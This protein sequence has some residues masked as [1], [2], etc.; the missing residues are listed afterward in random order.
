[1]S[2]TVSNSLLKDVKKALQNGTY[3]N[4]NLARGGKLVLDKMTPFLLVYRFSGAAPD[5]YFGALVRTQTAFLIA[6]EDYDLNKLIRIICEGQ[7]RRFNSFLIIE[8]WE[9][10]DSDYHIFAPQ[11]KVATTVSTLKDALEQ[12]PGYKVP[13]QTTDTADRNPPE[14]EPLLSHDEMHK[15]GVLVI[16]LEIPHT[17]GD[18]SRGEVYPI[19]FRQFRKAFSEAL[20]KAAFDF[21]RVQTNAGFDHYWRLGKSKITNRVRAVDQQLS[22]LSERIDL[23]MRVTPVNEHQQWLRFRKNNF[24]TPPNFSYRLITIDPDEE[25][26]RLFNIPV[27][28]IEDPTLMHIY[29]EK[30]NALEKELIMLE[31]RETDRFV[32]MSQNLIG[33]VR[34]ETTAQANHILEVTRHVPDPDRD[35]MVDCHDFFNAARDELAHYREEF[36]FERLHPEIRDDISGLMVSRGKLLIGTN[37]SVPRIQM[38][39]MLQHEVGT[40]VLTYCNGRRQPMGLLCRGLANYDAL[41]EGMA[42]L[43]EYLADGLITARMRVLAARVIAVNA[44]VNGYDFISTFNLLH[45]EHRFSP[46]KAFDITGRVFRG[47]GYTKDAIYLQGLLGLLDY[48]ENGG[49]LRILFAGKFALE[50]VAFIDE[51]IHREVISEPITPRLLDTPEAKEKLSHIRAGA[52]PTDLITDYHENSIHR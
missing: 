43:M 15:L 1:M 14:V 50:H 10:E 18:R 36:G 49:D 45:E 51:L 5:K 52:G 42:V 25:K 40:H 29:R 37:F 32:T 4:R 44:V 23:L 39:A 3:I 30:R 2:A 26:R 38:N 41:Q 13:V 6:H 12:L 19:R 31:E 35:D 17:Y 34:K 11:S 8:L 47:G 24:R 20:K 28:R 16:G 48:L 46:E 27:D 33:P 21:S 9:G 7:S 22:G